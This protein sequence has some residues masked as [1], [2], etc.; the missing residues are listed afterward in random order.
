MP[1]IDPSWRSGQSLG[2]RGGLIIDLHGNTIRD[3]LPAVSETDPI[4][5]SPGQ[6]GS[7]G[8]SWSPDGR[9]IAIIHYLAQDSGRLLVFDQGASTA[10]VLA[11]DA[12]AITGWSPDGARIVFVSGDPFFPTRWDEERQRPTGPGSDAWIVGV[13]GGEPQ[14]IKH[15]G[16]GEVPILAWSDPGG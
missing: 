2:F 14:L 10:R 1:R 11:A 7:P 3:L 4:S 8:P 9:Q 15:L 16:Y 6:C 12:C 5:V 13:D